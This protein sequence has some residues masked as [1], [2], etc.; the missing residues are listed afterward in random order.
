MSTGELHE[1][2]YAPYAHRAAQGLTV[3]RERTRLAGGACG[4]LLSQPASHHPVQLVGV[5][6]LQHPAQRPLAR[7]DVPRGVRPTPDPQPRQR[8][9]RQLAGE[10]PIAV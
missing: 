1:R 9:L 10:L 3:H 2:V 8:R 4:R 6:V 7:R 5:Q